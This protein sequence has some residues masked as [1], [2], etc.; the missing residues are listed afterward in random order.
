MSVTYGKTT[1]TQ[2]TDPEVVAVQQS[3]QRVVDT[4]P[5]GKGWVDRFPFLQY[6]PIPEVLRLRQYHKEELALF[7]SQLDI[8]RQRIV[9]PIV[10]RSLFPLN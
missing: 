6:F 9:S 4:L 5:I 8:L 3:V 2:Y 1:P 7:N 10:T